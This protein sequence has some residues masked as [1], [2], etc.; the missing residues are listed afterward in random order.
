MLNLITPDEFEFNLGDKVKDQITGFAGIVTCRSQWLN[1]CNTYGLQTEKLKD[2]E[3]PQ[4][5]QH[6]DAPQ[7]KLVK[8]AAVKSRKVRAGGP[9][10]DVPV[11][12]R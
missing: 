10:K 9:V 12:N 7:L 2:G 5:R 3:V 6:F 4:D 1:G 11:P 8:A